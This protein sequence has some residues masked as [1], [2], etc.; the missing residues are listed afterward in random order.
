MVL[1]MFCVW[2]SPA[3]WDLLFQIL[4]IKH[5]QY[6][7]SSPT[8]YFVVGGARRR[9]PR[10]QTVQRGVGKTGQAAM[11]EVMNT[12]IVMR[13]T[14]HVQA[15]LT[16]SPHP[17]FTSCLSL[18]P[19]KCSCIAKSSSSSPSFLFTLKTRLICVWSQEI[20]RDF[21]FESL[22]P[23]R[24]RMESVRVCC[25]VVAECVFV[26]RVCVCVS[27]IQ[28]LISLENSRRVNRVAW[29]K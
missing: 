13:H 18:S 21:G 25:A 28:H 26:F 7:R 14:Q 15:A 23:G 24:L 29:E 9:P 22:D 2:D 20:K 3:V 11:E 8:R 19:E 6:F 16:T 10:T 12:S 4:N 17:L 1:E 5:V 27:H